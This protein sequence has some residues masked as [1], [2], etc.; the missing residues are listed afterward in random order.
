MLKQTIISV[1][2]ALATL[3]SNSR[4]DT[5]DDKH[6]FGLLHNIESKGTSAVYSFVILLYRLG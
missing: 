6:V 4:F 3:L 5:P 1:R 2:V